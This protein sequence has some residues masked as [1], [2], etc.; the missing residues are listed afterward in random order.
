MGAGGVLQ[1]ASVGVYEQVPPAQVPV[2]AYVLRSE[3][4]QVG[5]GGVLQV[6]PE[7]GSATQLP[8]T[9]P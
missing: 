6:T 1:A 5:P 7:Q 4:W 8:P 2:A 3:P 9:Q